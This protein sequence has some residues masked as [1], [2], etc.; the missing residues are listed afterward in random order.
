MFIFLQFSRNKNKFFFSIL[1]LRKKWLEHTKKAAASLQFLAFFSFFF[2]KKEKKRGKPM[3][4][5][6]Q[7]DTDIERKRWKTWGNDGK[8]RENEGG[9]QR[10]DDW[11]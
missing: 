2:G 3:K 6:C 8:K 10:G 7:K 1:K 4:R 11:K 9:R 5:M